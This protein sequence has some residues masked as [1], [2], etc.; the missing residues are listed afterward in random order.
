[1]KIINTKVKETIIRLINEDIGDNL[2]N[3]KTENELL[4]VLDNILP[5]GIGNYVNIKNGNLYVSYN[6]EYYYDGCGLEFPEEVKKV[7]DLFNE[8]KNK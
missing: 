4:R 5:K 1:M 7:F 8:Y 2:S 3:S 6:N